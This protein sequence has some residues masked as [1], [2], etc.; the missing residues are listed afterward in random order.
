MHADLTKE[1]SNEQLEKFVGKAFSFYQQKWQ[2]SKDDNNNPMS[3]NMAAFFLG[4]SWMIYRKMYKYALIAVGVII[5]ESMLEEMLGFTLAMT[6]GVNI[7]IALF[8]G[9]YGNAIY[10]RHVNNKINEINTSYPPQ[11]VETE[12]EKQGGV[13]MSFAI[14]ISLFFILLAVA[15]FWSSSTVVS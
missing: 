12:I 2:K 8:F 7:A 13:N 5:F 15:V 11:Q 10:Q 14:A 1:V 4:V 6:Y 3:W 9:F